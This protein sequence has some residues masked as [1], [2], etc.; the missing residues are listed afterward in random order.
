MNKYV[1]LF[2]NLINFH[3]FIFILKF[4][5]EKCDKPLNVH[6]KPVLLYKLVY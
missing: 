6:L 5:A 3:L 2:I 1:L 4:L